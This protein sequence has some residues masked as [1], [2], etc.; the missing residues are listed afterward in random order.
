[1]NRTHYCGN[2]NADHVGKEVE[3]CGWVARV[4]DLGNLTFIQLRDKTGIVQIALN[5][6]VSDKKIVEITK[7]LKSE[8][9]IN[10][11]GKVIKRTNENINKDMKTGEIEVVAEEINILNESKLPP[12]HIDDNVTVSENL[13]LKYRYLDLRRPFMN[14]ILT[15]RYN[16]IKSIREFLAYENFTEVETPFLIKSTPEGAR[17]FVVPS[18]LHSGKFYAL[19]QSPQLFKQLLMVSG[20]DKYFQIARCF[21]DEDARS[22]RQTDFTQL[23]ME[24]SFSD[25]NMI[26]ST[27]EKLLYKVFKENIGIELS[28]PFDR[29][30][31]DEAMEKYGSDK[32]ERRAGMELETLT[33][34]FKNTSFKVF[35]QAIEKSGVIKA[36]VLKNKAD[37]ISRKTV[38]IYEQLVK[39]NGAAGL[40]W[41]KY[42]NNEFEGGVSKFI[43]DKKEE[44]VGKLKIENNDIVFFGAGEKDIVN[45]YLGILRLHLI[46]EWNLL[47]KEEKKFDM[48]WVTDFPLFEK[49]D[50]GG[51]DAKH[52]LFSMPTDDTLQYV[53]SAPEKVYGRLYDL[54]CNGNELASGSIRIHNPQLQRKVMRVVGL[55]DEEMDRKF[56]FLLEAFEYGA[57]PHGGIAPGI[58]RLIMVM[59]GLDNLKDVIAFPKTNTQLCLLTDAPDYLSEEQLV[60][61]GLKVVS[62]DKE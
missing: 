51:Y 1:V 8:Y 3:L 5:T 13:R 44:L 62:T 18:R 28:L 39:K 2:V 38:D 11:K 37:Q 54:V 10:V 57:P 26:F 53:D 16:V 42:I 46:R 15:F 21:R 12:F 49:N 30:K 25:E 29:M 35:A 9:V 45:N 32:P 33:E 48:L 27:M 43:S 22:D 41:T 50:N 59:K 7:K 19:P 17:D 34:I 58:D 47:N 31:Y 55:T 6:E 56:G 61:L 20:V 40:A 52:H 14:N 60:E 23:D 36:V 4:R 24:M